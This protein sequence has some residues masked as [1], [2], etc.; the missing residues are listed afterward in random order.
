MQNTGSGAY[1]F[2][3]VFCLLSFAWSFAFVPETL[4]RSLEAMDRV[5]GDAS[6]EREEAR[7]ATIENDINASVSVPSEASHG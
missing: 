1:T 6:S 5:F 7:R 2:F 4:G 3:A